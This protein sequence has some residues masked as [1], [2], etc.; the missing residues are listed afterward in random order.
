MTLVKLMILG[1]PIPPKE[2]CVDLIA[3]VKNIEAER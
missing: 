1:S 2:E 3:L